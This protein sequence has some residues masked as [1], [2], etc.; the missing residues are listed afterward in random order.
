V[1]Q[2]TNPRQSWIDLFTAGV[3]VAPPRWWY[4]PINP[5]SL[6]LTRE[7]Y[8]W[9]NKHTKIRPHKIKLQRGLGGRQFLQLERL[10]TAPYLVDTYKCIAVIDE[11]T[12]IMLQ[13]HAGDL[14]TYLQNLEDNQ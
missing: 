10:L 7:A 5:K 4:N 9:I 8:T 6:R 1:T 11:T 14:N 12:L 3:T 13:L 2:S